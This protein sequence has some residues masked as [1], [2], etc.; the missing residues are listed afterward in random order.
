MKQRTVKGYGWQ[1]S[2]PDNRDFFFKVTAPVPLPSSVDLRDQCPPIYDQGALGACSSHAIGAAY[3]FGLMKQGKPVFMPSRLFLYY[4]ERFI[5]NT[6]N[7][8]SGAQMK[9]GLKSLNK[10]GIC[11]ENLW[12]YKICKFKKKPP[13]KAYDAAKLNTIELYEKIPDGNLF[14]MKQCL[15]KGIPF[16]FGFTVYES[17]E[18]EE[19]AKTGLMP[20]WNPNESIM[21]GHAVMSVGYDTEKQV[22]IVRNSWGSNWADN[23][24]F[25]MPFSYI[26]NQNLASDF[27]CINAV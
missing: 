27:W 16:V 4:N 5:E 2:L 6:V 12:K 19:I 13:Q 8:D 22:M 1:R 10:D 18:G 9:D 15:A 24:Y 17:F 7:Y 21:G 26:S 25:Y 14:L 3:Q 11:D 23:G 20:E